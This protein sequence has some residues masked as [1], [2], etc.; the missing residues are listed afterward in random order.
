MQVCKCA[1]MQVCKYAGMQVCKYASTQVCKY[2]TCSVGTSVP[3]L[4]SM[5]VLLFPLPKDYVSTSVPLTKDCV[6]D[7]VPHP[8]LQIVFVLMSPP[9]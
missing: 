1:S 9:I 4:M 7:S 3:P 5:L 8:Y 6:R 2:A